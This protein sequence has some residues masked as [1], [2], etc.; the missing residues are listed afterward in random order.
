MK[1][2]VPSAALLV[3]SPG[4]DPYSLLP[5]CQTGSPPFP[6]GGKVETGFRGRLR[7]CEKKILGGC[8]GRRRSRATSSGKAE[9]TLLC[10]ASCVFVS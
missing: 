6:G 8:S 5:P 10:K 9:A 1:A 4:G 3:G 7:G 2:S